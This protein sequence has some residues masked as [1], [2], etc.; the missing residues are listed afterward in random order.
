MHKIYLKK[1][2]WKQK[3]KAIGDHLVIGKR[4]GK[5]MRENEIKIHL[6]NNW[7]CFDNCILFLVNI[8]KFQLQISYKNSICYICIYFILPEHWQKATSVTETI[9]PIFNFNISISTFYFQ[10]DHNFYIW[11]SLRYIGIYRITNCANFD[12][13]SYL[14]NLSFLY[15]MDYK[16]HLRRYNL[17]H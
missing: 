12:V 7:Y 2:I 3:Y 16:M 11:Q 15:S 14:S 1:T 10:S 6:N 13:M 9:T 4:S 5:A 17:Q 8:W